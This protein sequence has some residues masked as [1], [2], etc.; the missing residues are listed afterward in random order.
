MEEKE[1]SE[2]PD[3]TANF[4]ISNQVLGASTWA[5]DL[6]IRLVVNREPFISSQ[7]S[8]DLV[9]GEKLCGGC[10]DF[11]FSEDFLSGETDD[12]KLVSCY[13]NGIVRLW[14]LGMLFYI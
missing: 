14:S 7:L 11:D 5:G 1:N 9:S 4:E 6:H 12:V 10:T 13:G 8:F 2:N 3:P